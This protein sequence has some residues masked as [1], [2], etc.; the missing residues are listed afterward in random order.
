MS[1][2]ANGR[3]PRIDQGRRASSPGRPARRG[4]GA[5]RRD[6][7]LLDNHAHV[8][9]CLAGDPGLRL[10]DLAVRIGIT[11]RAVQELVNDLEREG[12]LRRRRAGRRNRY[13]LDLRS[14]LGHPIEQHRTVEE[15]VRFLTR[16]R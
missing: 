16:S 1:S 7:T 10:R 6:W 4:R 9:V 12:L 11:E 5:S 2:P 13:E 8:L 15:L 14:P 3:P